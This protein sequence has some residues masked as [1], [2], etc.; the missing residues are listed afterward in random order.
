MR[1]LDAHLE[2]FRWRQGWRAARQSTC[3]RE[4]SGQMVSKARVQ[5]KAISDERGSRMSREERLSAQEASGSP[6][7]T[8]AHGPLPVP[9]YF[10]IT[11]RTHARSLTHSLTHPLTHSLTPTNPHLP[12]G[13]LRGPL[14]VGKGTIYEGVKVPRRRVEHAR[15]KCRQFRIPQSS[16]SFHDGR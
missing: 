13:R 10:S 16:G 15:V 4:A 6:R 9:V 5:R 3:A 12:R 11:D 14:S 8:S 7:P 2:R 1:A